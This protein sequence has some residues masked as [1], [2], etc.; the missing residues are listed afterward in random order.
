MKLGLA[1]REIRKAKRWNQR[2]LAL[3]SGLS[4][5]FISLMERGKR[6]VHSDS[7]DKIAKAL[8]IPPSFIYVLADNADD[9]VL[10]TLQRTIKKTLRIS[11]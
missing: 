11:T 4:Y 5:N 7:V 10:K 8:K 9:V 1:I 2:A 3:K 6:G